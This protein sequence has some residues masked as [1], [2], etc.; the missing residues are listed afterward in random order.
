MTVSWV[1]PADDG[2]SPVTEYR[3]TSVPGGAICTSSTVSCVVSGLA[4]GTP[5]SFTV[6]AKNAIGISAPVRA[7]RTG[8]PDRPVTPQSMVT[9]PGRVTGVKAKVRKR[10][11]K[12]RWKAVAGATSYRVRISKPGG[13]EYKAW[14]T[15]T[16]L[17]FKAKVKK[18]KKYRVPIGAVGPGG[19]GPV[20]TKRFT[21]K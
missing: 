17:V 9:A 4:N 15:T 3:A 7:L 21:A 10:K 19:R 14:K 20:T 8:D 5:C 1:P 18:G 12:V 6:T 16:K 11:V 13:K 2:G